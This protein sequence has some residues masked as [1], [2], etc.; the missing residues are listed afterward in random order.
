MFLVYC[1]FFGSIVVSIVKFQVLFKLFEVRQDIFIILFIVVQC[2]LLVI[3]CLMALN[4]NYGV[5]VVVVFQY[6]I[7]WLVYL[8]VV[9]MN[10]RSRIIILVEGILEKFVECQWN[11]NG[12]IIIFFIGF[13]Q[14]YLVV[15]LSRKVVGQQVI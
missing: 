3:I 5:D 10:L 1:Q 6:F 2:S 7:F 12:F 13:Q 4:V 8:L 11:V 9:Y 14:E 15:G